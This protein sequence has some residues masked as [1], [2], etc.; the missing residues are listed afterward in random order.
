MKK[1]LGLMLFATFFCGSVK[2]AYLDSIFQHPTS[3]QISGGAL[4]NSGMTPT[5]GAT[6]LALVYHSANVSNTL[7]PQVLLDLGV[8]P[9]SWAINIGL[10]GNAG[11]AMVP[12]GASVNLVPSALGP[13][14][15]LMSASSN[16]TVQQISRV[17]AS[18]SGGCAFGPTWTAYPVVNG[19]WKPMNAWR[20]PPGWFL[21]ASYKF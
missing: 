7:M 18:E 17:I 8:R 3:P 6:E 9:M 10:G 15:D 12:L 21:G 4:L 5:G 19:G 14:L 20:F 16:L 11:N 2:A 13:V 1:I